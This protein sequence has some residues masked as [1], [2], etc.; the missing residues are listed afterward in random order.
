VLLVAVDGRQFNGWRGWMRARIGKDGWLGHAT[1]VEDGALRMR[2]ICM[3]R[4][5]R[6]G[7]P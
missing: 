4:F 3:G 2:V 1:M 7:L 6:Q 5:G